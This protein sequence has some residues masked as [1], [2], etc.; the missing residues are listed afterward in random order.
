MATIPET[1]NGV[2][3]EFAEGVN[4]DV[5]HSMLK[6]LVH[7]IKKNVSAEHTLTSIYIASASDSH[8]FPS[9]HSMKKAVDISRI[10]GTKIVLGYPGNKLV[11]SI[12]AAIQTTFESYRGRRENFGPFLKK[13][14]GTDFI[15]DGH[16]DHIHLSVN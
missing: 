14:S 16:K 15:I 6:G 10:N 12:V 11:K 8:Q 7:C 9:R 1:I 5:D 13:K 4:K 2:T 3:I